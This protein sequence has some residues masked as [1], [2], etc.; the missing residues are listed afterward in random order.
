MQ[1]PIWH[2]ADRLFSIDS[3]PSLEVL[4]SCPVMFFSIL[5]CFHFDEFNHL[6]Q[7]RHKD[8]LPETNAVRLF[9]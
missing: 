7:P 4:R 3:E 6:G 2:K 9:Q 5:R 8:Q 1:R